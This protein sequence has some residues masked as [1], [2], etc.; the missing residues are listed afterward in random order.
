MSNRLT[1]RFSNHLA[2]GVCMGWACTRTHVAGTCL[3]GRAGAACKA[4]G[5]RDTRC[6]A[7]GLGKKKESTPRKPGFVFLTSAA[8]DVAQEPALLGPF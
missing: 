6:D 7:K 4:L 2:E 8:L 1:R 5:L 3:G